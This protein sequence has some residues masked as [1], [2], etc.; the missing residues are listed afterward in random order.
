[1]GAED[2]EMALM[3]FLNFGGHESW[4]QSGHIAYQK[5]RYK[6]W[7]FQ[8][9][10]KPQSGD[11]ICGVSAF[12][13]AEVIRVLHISIRTSPT[14]G[15]AQ[16]PC[17]VAD[18]TSENETSPVAPLRETRAGCSQLSP[19]SDEESCKQLVLEFQRAQTL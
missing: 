9:N 16:H 4:R 2:C 15:S 1:M 3:W 6:G 17:R 7:N 18:R 14:P 8:Q 5:Q 10:T 12:R 13:S 19:W 11:D